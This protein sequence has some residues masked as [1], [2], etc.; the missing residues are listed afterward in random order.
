[1]APTTTPTPTPTVPVPD[2][3]LCHDWQLVSPPSRV[4]AV[5]ALRA[6]RATGARIADYAGPW[7]DDYPAVPCSCVTGGAR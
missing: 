3:A 4:A 2:C 5:A 7:P 1:M 6:Y